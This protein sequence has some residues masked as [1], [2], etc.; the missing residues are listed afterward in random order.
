[1]YTHQDIQEFNKQIKEL[2]DKGLIRN[3]ES[4]HASPTF[5]VRNHIEEKRG[6]ARIVINYKNL[7]ITLSLMVTIFLTKQSFLT[8]FKELLGS[9]KW[10]ARVVIGR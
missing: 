8:E 1:M 2:L 3:R 5:M 4:P 10:I 6:K 9:R 7:M